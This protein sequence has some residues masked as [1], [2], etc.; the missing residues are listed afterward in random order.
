MGKHRQAG[1]LENGFRLDLVDANNRSGNTATRIGNAQE[2]AESLET[3]IF[4]AP[5][6]KG[7]PNQ[8][9]ATAGKGG[10]GRPGPM[11]GL[12]ENSAAVFGTG[13]IDPRFDV[14]MDCSGFK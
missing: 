10:P 3:A 14:R 12:P 7:W 4:A 9:P 5:A 1:Y 11:G 6:M 13:R 8:I 2:L